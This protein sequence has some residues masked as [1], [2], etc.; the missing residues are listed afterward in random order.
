LYPIHQG[1]RL[2]QPSFQFATVIRRPNFISYRRHLAEANAT[3]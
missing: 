3:E 2:A 1:A